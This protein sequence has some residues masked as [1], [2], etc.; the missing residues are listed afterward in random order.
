M[1]GKV[2]WPNDLGGGAGSWSTEVCGA[3]ADAGSSAYSPARPGLSI[4]VEMP[5][6]SFLLGH[7]HSAFLPIISKTTEYGT[8]NLRKGEMEKHGE[9]TFKL[10]IVNHSRR[11]VSLC[12]KNHN[13]GVKPG[14]FPRFKSLTQHS[15]KAE[16]LA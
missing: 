15:G 11:I 9:R 7:C 13:V 4:C 16:V 8:G 3:G 10:M 14:V 2:P 5:D 1:L 12:Q 6:R